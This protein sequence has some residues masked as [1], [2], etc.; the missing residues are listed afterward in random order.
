MNNLSPTIEKIRKEITEILEK[1]CGQTCPNGGGLY[2]PSIDKL[3]ILFT[4]KL[5]DV[6]GETRYKT[7]NSIREALHD[8]PNFVEISRRLYKVSQ[9]E[10]LIEL[11]HLKRSEGKECSHSE[12]K[13]CKYCEEKS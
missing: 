1:D 9:K 13:L 4:E 3:V 12:G 7:D 6:E 5:Q 11:S 2:R 10:A 8:L